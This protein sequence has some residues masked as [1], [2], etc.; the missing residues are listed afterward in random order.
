M[1]EGAMPTRRMR[2]PAPSA[3]TCGCAS[4]KSTWAAAA[5]KG[6]KRS[7]L[8]R[9]GWLRLERKVSGGGRWGSRVFVILLSR[10]PASA[11]SGR[12]GEN[13]HSFSSRSLVPPSVASTWHMPSQALFLRSRSAI[14]DGR[15]IYAS[16]RPG[17]VCC[18][19]DGS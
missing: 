9:T 10:Q 13:E 3:P 2:T 18:L 14:W 16:A 5:G 8:V 4:W 7:E 15:Q 6:R 17:N 19:S 1:V 12:S 11:Q